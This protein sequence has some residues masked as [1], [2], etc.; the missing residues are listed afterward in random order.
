M[1]YYYY[2]YYYESFPLDTPNIP[3]SSSVYNVTEILII[4]RCIIIIQLTNATIITTIE[5]I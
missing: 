5:I 4:V 3:F 1:L 2:I